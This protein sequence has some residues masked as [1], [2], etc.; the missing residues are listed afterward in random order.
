EGLWLDAGV[1]SSHLGFE[2]AVSIDYPTLTR[3]LVSEGSPYFLTGAKLTHK[4]NDKW[5][6][7]AVV[8]NGWQRIQ[9][10]AGNSLPCVGTQV[11][12]MPNRNTL[13]NWSTLIGTDDPDSTRRMRYFNNL[14]AQFQLDDD[15]NLSVGFDAGMQQ[16]SKG[17]SSYNTW[18]APVVVFGY[19]FTGQVAAGFRAEY[20]GD[21]ENVIMQT[22]SGEVFNTSGISLNFDYRPS[23]EIACRI[24]G[25]YFHSKNQIFVKD[26]TYT[27][28]NFV[29]TGSIAVMLEHVFTGRR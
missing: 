23:P 3:S 20:F 29:I 4:P 9:R 27:D 8:S 26:G 18:Y 2:G 15:M 13:L 24:E 25:R 10:V 5:E 16:Q 7:L 12:Y 17:S 28:R 21:E 1:F 11:K 22:S 14:Y 19:K 6:L